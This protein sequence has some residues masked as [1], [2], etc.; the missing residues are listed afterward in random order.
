VNPPWGS[1]IVCSASMHEYD[2]HTNYQII[3]VDREFPFRHS[4]YLHSYED[5]RFKNLPLFKT[6]RFVD[7]AILNN[8]IQ[9]VVLDKLR[10]I[11]KKKTTESTDQ[12][13]A[14]AIIIQID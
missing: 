5:K 10:T 3:D 2:P 1:Y 6:F 8:S 14:K 9:Y 4:Q 7:P 13:K 11:E 12:K